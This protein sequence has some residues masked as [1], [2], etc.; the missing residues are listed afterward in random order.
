MIT[1]PLFD[2]GEP[3]HKPVREGEKV[4]SVLRDAYMRQQY[5]HGPAGLTCGTCALFVRGVR[6]TKRDIVLEDGSVV[7]EKVPTGACQLYT[8]G[9][10]TAWK[11]GAQ[12]CAWWEGKGE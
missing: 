7:K 9:P 6:E 3:V 4:K 10:S 2:F 12:A 11:E 8:G 5:G 1:T